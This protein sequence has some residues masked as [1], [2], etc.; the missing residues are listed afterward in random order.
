[1][2]SDLDADTIAASLT[3]DFG[4][5]LRYV[6]EIASTNTAAMEW[7]TRGAPHGAVVVTDHQTGGRGR[8]GR[9]WFSLPGKLLQFS[10]ILRSELE[11]ERH[12]LLTAALGVAVADALGPITGRATTIKWP[13]D[14]LVNDKKVAGILVETHTT[15]ST[16]VIA[17]CGVGIN[18]S[19]ERD[20]LPPE[21]AARASSLLLETT[22]ELPDRSALLA[23][24]LRE[25]ETRCA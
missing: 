3:G 25:I 5:A 8:W 15:G 6:D 21:I 23:A 24:V 18:V 12:G 19:L 14:V 7:A 22:R 17:V 11:V 2:A 16:I 4:R 13:N 1:M 10:L 20:D 9:S